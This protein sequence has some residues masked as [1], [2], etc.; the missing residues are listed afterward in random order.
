MSNKKKIGD[1]DRLNSIS[2]Q[3]GYSLSEDLFSK[4]RDMILTENLPEGYVFPNENELCKIFEVG[5]STLRE[6][7]S[8]L[9]TLGLITRTKS[10]TYVND[11]KKIQG[12]FS[13]DTMVKASDLGDLMEFRRILETELVMIAATKATPK[14]IERLEDCHDFIKNN[15]ENVVAITIYDMQFHLVIADISGNKLM[16][17]IFDTIRSHM[18]N[19]IYHAFT[20]DRTMIDK[21]IISHDQII[22]AIKAGD[23]ERARE[24]MLMHMSNVSL[25]LGV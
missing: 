11:I 13:F 14:D 19:L 16:I 2:L 9:A 24:A 12:S 23:P 10:G 22:N 4:L 1:M 6:A 3:H 17:R 21:A 8:R 7:Y 5:R 18:E 15:I 25:Q 20:R